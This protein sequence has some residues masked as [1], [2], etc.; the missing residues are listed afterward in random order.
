MAERSARHNEFVIERTYPVSPER[1]FAALSDPAQKRRWFMQGE[2][3]DL[4]FE[5]DFRVGGREYSRSRIQKGPFA[6]TA[7]TSEGVFLD[8]VVNRRVVTGCAMTLG[9]RRISASLATFEL[10]PAEKGTTLIFT[11]QAAFFEGSDG[12]QMREAGWRALLD[13]LN[14]SLAA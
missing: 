5:M 4:E 8:I 11:H 10:L 6:G 1:L 2:G 12:P 7:L 13:R 14:A 3:D 9:E